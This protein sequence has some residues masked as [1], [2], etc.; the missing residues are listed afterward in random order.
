MGS[1]S[2]SLRDIFEASCAIQ[3]FLAPTAHHAA[4]RSPSPI[5]HSEIIQ[6]LNNQPGWAQNATILQVSERAFYR[7]PSKKGFGQSRNQ[8][9]ILLACK[10]ALL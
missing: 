6:Q 1:G 7:L 8:G 4:V 10:P 2:D 3:A 9:S 5:K